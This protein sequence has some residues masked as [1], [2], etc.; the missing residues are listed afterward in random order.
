[1]FGRHDVFYEVTIFQAPPTFFRTN[2]LTSAFQGL[3]NAYG[4]A[5]YREANPAVFTIVTFPFLFAIMF[6]DAG[7][8]LIMFG[9]IFKEEK[10]SFL[11]IFYLFRV[12]SVVHPQGEETYVREVRQ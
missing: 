1:M 5:T 10:M 11:C 3:I 6:G 4:V 7:H 9:R 8:G 2:K 12:C